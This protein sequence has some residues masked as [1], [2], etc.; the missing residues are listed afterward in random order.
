MNLGEFRNTGL[1]VE[2]TQKLGDKWQYNAGFT[3]QN[4]EA[5]DSGVWVQETSRWQMTTGV[6]YT[7]GKFHS[8]LNLFWAGDREDASKTINGK[9]HALRDKVDLNAVLSYTP[10]QYNSFKL[11]L[12][13]LLN[14]DNVMNVS[15]NLARPFNW[16]MT[17]TCTF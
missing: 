11:N 5:K 17:Y 4:P 3:V 16:S 14:R 9:Y 7:T 8:S 13:N 12:Y 2:Y 10:D 1:E 15:E 6:Q